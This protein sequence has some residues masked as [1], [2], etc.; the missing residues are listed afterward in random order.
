MSQPKPEV[1]V[2]TTFTFTCA[3]GC[4]VHV[5][6]TQEQPHAC[7]GVSLIA[8]AWRVLPADVTVL[9]AA[10]RIAEALKPLINEQSFD[11]WVDGVRVGRTGQLCY[12]VPEDAAAIA[13]E[14]GARP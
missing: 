12:G 3:Y 4:T 5:V 9:Q 6:D 8:D 1:D 2:F 14:D 10:E 13:A 11:S 7:E